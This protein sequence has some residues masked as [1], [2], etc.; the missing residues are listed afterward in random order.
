[1]GKLEGN[2]TSALK[3]FIICQP[4][5]DI[6][7]YFSMEY[8]NLPLTIGIAIRI[9]FMGY[10][11]LYIFWE[12]ESRWKKQVIF[13]LGILFAVLGFSF[14]LNY[15]TK[16]DFIL[17]DEIQYYVKNL[18]FPVLNSAL[19]LAQ[20][21]RDHKT[22][23]KLYELIPS[24]MFI[25]SLSLFLA[26]LTGTSN[27]TYQFQEGYL[28]WFFAGNEISAILAICFPVVL[29]S[30]KNEQNHRKRSFFLLCLF[31][32]MAAAL[33]IGT[34]VSYFSILL[35]LIIAVFGTIIQ[36]VFLEKKIPVKKTAVLFLAMIVSY[37]AATPFTP[38]YNNL[39]GFFQRLS[40]EK[41]FA[42]SEKEV[43]EE[44]S[45]EH[46]QESDLPDQEASNG[47]LSVI[48]SK[49]DIHLQNLLEDYKDA[50]IIHQLF[51]LGYAGFYEGEPKL[52]EMDFFD[53]F[54]SF[55][56]VG[57]LIMLLPFFVI[58][59][60]LL[61]FLFRQPKR[62]FHP[63]HINLLISLFLGLGIAFFAGHVLYAPAVSIYLA[64]VFVLL[65]HYYSL[66]HEN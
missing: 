20:A 39:G 53:I 46:E 32:M 7:T 60:D 8:W 44:P 30:F 62:F 29:Y 64:M 34:K 59:K 52:A 26:V 17:F 2:F 40:I 24:A 22:G 42:D 25:L 36:K 63:E 28:G 61:K 18:Y 33:L 55:G 56:I 31:M 48:L 14:L 37:I 65:L 4:I 13:Y 38:S 47:F 21:D 1:M 57:F 45:A 19:L 3:A 6:L 35:T 5:L 12:K 41:Q 27:R 9:L 66:P 23:V 58:V 10:S 50:G 15:F 16:P 54:I 51:G 43:L 49:R 11:L